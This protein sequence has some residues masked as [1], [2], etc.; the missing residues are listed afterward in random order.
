M[1][2]ELTE[3]QV[4]WQEQFRAFVDKGIVPY[5]GQNDKEEI[6]HPAVVAGMRDAGYLGSMLPEA[7]GGMGLDEVSLGVLNEEVGRG[8]TSARNLLTVH[9]MVGLAILRWGTQEQKDAWL[10]RLAR[11][12]IIGAFGLSEPDVGSDA[13][14]IH[15][16]AVEDGDEYVITGSKKWITMG[17]IADVFLI[18]AQFE[19]KPTAFLVESTRAGFG[20]TPILGMMGSRGSMLA[21][22]QLDNVRIPKSN[23]VGKL[24]TGL[25]HVALSCLDYGRYTVAWGCI[26]LAQAC[27][28]ASVEY[29]KTRQQFGKPLGEFQLIQKMLT[30]MVVSIKGARLLCYRSGYLKQIGDP[31]SILET[32]TAKYAASVMV[33]KVSG[34]A[35]QIHGG[36][37]CHDSY[38]VERYYRD[39]KI[40]EI[41][42]GSTQV[43]EYLIARNLL[44]TM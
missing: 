14:S 42:E 6:L 34:D 17:M 22:L 41:I 44:Q 11:G 2:I 38:P 37:G 28:E 35:V 12:E 24:G 3:A 4:A 31:D 21:E 18:F 29:A 40:N 23:L 8:C 7:Y 9:G 27:L 13:K 15:T 10:P 30:E 19:G 32:W 36:N 20:R 25:S 43:H 39:A 1:I 26:G 33:T 16:T 5:A